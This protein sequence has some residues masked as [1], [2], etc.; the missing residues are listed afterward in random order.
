MLC[1]HDN[2]GGENPME[3]DKNKEELD[4]IVTRFEGIRLLKMLIEMSLVAAG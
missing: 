4:D 3:E 2:N 1:G